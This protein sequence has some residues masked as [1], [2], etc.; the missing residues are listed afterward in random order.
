MEISEVRSFMGRRSPLFWGMVY[1][2]QIFVFTGIYHLVPA[3]FSI[4]Q[5]TSLGK[6]DAFYVSVV[7]ITTLGYGDITPATEL[8]KFICAL[9]AVFGIFNLGLFLNSVSLKIEREFERVQNDITKKS[10]KGVWSIVH[11][12]IHQS[13]DR[14][15]RALIGDLGANSEKMY[16]TYGDHSFIARDVSGHGISVKPTAFVQAIC[17]NA[18]GFVGH[19]GEAAD[20]IET[21]ISSVE[22][23]IGPYSWVIDPHLL[24]ELLSLLKEGELALDMIAELAVH[25]ESDVPDALASLYGAS[26]GLKMKLVETHGAMMALADSC[27]DR[28]AHSARIKQ[29]LDDLKQRV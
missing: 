28:E 11:M 1:L 3:L 8:G 24:S 7:T 9:E 27:E 22:N 17:R 12:N 6:M 15:T 2:V 14:A 16:I 20:A 5:N 23:Q 25:D 21:L 18:T 19:K 26:F 10:Q 13:L 4:D 29:V